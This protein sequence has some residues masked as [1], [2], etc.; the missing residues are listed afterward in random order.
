MMGASAEVAMSQE[1]RWRFAKA[2]LALLICAVVAIAYWLY[3]ALFPELPAGSVGNDALFLA[4]GARRIAAG[5]VPHKDFHLPTG[6]LPFFTYLYAER[7]F[8][9]LPAYIGA[10]LLGFLLISP[11]LVAAMSQIE[12]WPHALALGSLVAVA[13]LLPFNTSRGEDFGLVF[14]AS[15]N[16]L[17]TAL[18]LAYLAWLFGANPSSRATGGIVIAYALLMALFLKIV[19]AGVILAPLTILA[20]MNRRWRPAAAAGGVIVVAV[21]LLLE[22]ETE[23]V[24]GYIADISAMSAINRNSVPYFFASFIF[25][26]I[27]LQALVGVLILW[28]LVERWHA[29]SPHDRWDALSIPLAM[30][31]AVGALSLAESQSTGGLE[32]AGA[33]GL[34][35]AKSFIGGGLQIGRVA[36]YVAAASLL[37]GP[38]LIGAFENTIA[39]SLD[40]QGKPVEVHWVARFMPRTVVP[41][42]MVNKAEAMVALWDSVEMT[43]AARSNLGAQ[44]VNRSDPDLYLAQWLTVDRALQRLAERRYEDLGRVATLANVDFFG[45]AID[46]QRARGL[47]VVHDVGRTILPLTSGQA[48][49]YIADADTVFVPNCAMNEAPGFERMSLWFKGVL[50]AEFSSAMLTPCWMVHRRNPTAG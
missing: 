43:T 8:P 34:L 17:S 36:S 3:W 22:M 29:S 44:L 18:S 19:A 39:L 15:Y 45:F 25:K 1:A 9:Q 2:T 10:H 49:T 41:E 42:P 33:L 23:I 27:A 40:R 26:T 46:A 4:D 21:L 6:A 12:R 28:M 38:L 32:F 35:F 5:Q 7:L 47:K 31:A 16:R 37:A 11:I 50:E 13:A 48:R 24:S 30:M 14:H 20:F